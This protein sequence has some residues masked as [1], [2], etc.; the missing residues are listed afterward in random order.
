MSTTKVTEAEA[1]LNPGALKP[2][3]HEDDFLIISWHN[4]DAAPNDA[5]LHFPY[6]R[7]LA[8]GQDGRRALSELCSKRVRN[9]FYTH[10][11]LRAGTP[12]FWERLRLLALLGG[13]DLIHIDHF[14]TITG[15]IK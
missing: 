6:Y 4:G 13:G 11:A 3:A 9:I 5:D 7:V 8:V 10:H 14:D 2:Y 1:N 15:E 12:A